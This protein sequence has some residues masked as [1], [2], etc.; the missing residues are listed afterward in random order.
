MKTILNL[1][2]KS[3]LS[4]V[5]FA[6]ILCGIYPLLVWGLGQFFFPHQANGSLI[7]D[8]TKNPIGSQL[9]GENFFSEKYFHPRPSSAGK[10]GYDGA[11]SAASNFG[12]TSRKLEKA[13]TLY[14]Q[15]Y[16]ERNGLDETVPLPIDAITSSGSGL[17][18]HIS[19]D[20]AFLQL[21]RVAKTRGISENTLKK[22]IH[23]QTEERTFGVLGEPRI[24]VL[25]LNLKLDEMP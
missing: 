4:L 1:L 14:S 23:K 11:N 10:E 19:V 22:L 21:P 15:T 17:D 25:L 16:R 13:L 8:K 5:F 9:I 12:P 20:N 6:L 2:K 18:P 3:I 7:F 24:N